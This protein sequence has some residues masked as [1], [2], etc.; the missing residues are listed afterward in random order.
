MIVLNKRNAFGIGTYNRR[1]MNQPLVV[2][3]LVLPE[4]TNKL[5]GSVVKIWN[6]NEH[7]LDAYYPTIQNSILANIEYEYDEAGSGSCQINFLERS[8]IGFAS[9]GIV[10]IDKETRRYKGYIN[11]FPDDGTNTKEIYTYK[12]KGL[13]ERLKQM[14]IEVLQKY[15]IQSISQSG[16]NSTFTISETLDY[17][18]IG[19]M[20][21][22]EN[23]SDKLNNTNSIITSYTSS[24]V[25]C[26]NPLGLNQALP[27]GEFRIL[28]YEWSVPTKISDI[29][30]QVILEY[31]SRYN[32]GITFNTLKIDDS[33]G[34][35]SQGW[36]DLDTLTIDKVFDGLRKMLNGA[37]ILGVDED[38]EFFFRKI[39]SEPLDYLYIGYQ[40]HE[41]EIKAKP[42][43]IFNRITVFRKNGKQETGTG[44]SVGA[45]GGPLD[46]ANISAA[47]YGDRYKEINVPTFFSDEANQLIADNALS[48][49]KDLRYTLK[50]NNLPNDKKYEIGIYQIISPPV[51]RKLIISEHDTLSGW[52]IQVG[53]RA[54][55]NTEILNTGFGS[56]RY[57]VDATSNGKT[58]T[59][60]CDI[61]LASRKNLNV[62]I[63]SNKIGAYV[64]ISITDGVNIYTSEIRI[65]VTNTFILFVW[66]ISN[67]P[68]AKINQV[69]YTFKNCVTTGVAPTHF[70]FFDELSVD[71]FG[72]IRYNVP[73]QKVK[74]KE[75]EHSTDVDL[76]FG[77]EFD[78]LS[79]YLLGLQ[80]L[81]EN[82]ILTQR[83]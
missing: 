17:N 79:D 37:Y 78:K 6:R 31:A 35:T 75:M 44:L 29:F 72:A 59:Y 76:Q 66:D 18:P 12:I 30:K 9:F 54:S 55:L 4:N 62:W 60:D 49:Y 52:N 70:I 11:E 73:L 45:I 56:T 28:P 50:I 57:A 14:T 36:I 2:K 53:L 34:Y 40:A 10:T 47:K 41:P 33:V 58:A 25:T 16:T 22:S 74:V 43:D 48:R 13:R 67:L 83:S 63:R 80:A 5:G 81:S 42:G 19:R 26:Y 61:Y 38:G 20:L 7:L 32:N 3:E 27:Q 65:D 77:E 39:E 23:C 15:D 8:K 82:S 1:A 24:T 68:I 64:D 51:D 46:D 21:V 69:K 71:I